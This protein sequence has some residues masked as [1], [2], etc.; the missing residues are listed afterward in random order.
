MPSRIATLVVALATFLPMGIALAE[1]AAN[2]DSLRLGARYL[3]WT[4]TGGGST[5]STLTIGGNA[6]V[7]PTNTPANTAAAPVPQNAVAPEVLLPQPGITLAELEATAEQ[8]NPTLTQAAAAV[9]AAH[10]QWLQSGLYPNPRVGYQASE[11]G[12]EGQAGQQGAMFGQEIVTAGKLQRA[13]DVDDQ[14]IQQAQWAWAAQRQRVQNDV[15]RAFYDV[16]VAQRSVELADQL[17]R[18]GQQGVNA[19]EALLK[20]KEVS[21]VDVLQARIE[22]DT[23]RIFADKAHNR[24][25]AAWR[26]LAAVVGVPNMQPGTLTGE[27]QDG[28]ALLTWDEALHSVLTDSPALAEA[29][30]GVARA[31]AAVGRECAGACRTST[32]RPACSTTTP[33]A[34]RLPKFRWECPCRP[35]IATR[36]TYARRRPN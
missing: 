25:L 35:S 24:H 10:G 18:I 7:A 34:T 19:A 30:A 9:Q 36:G 22:A 23:A 32:Y 13:R 28:L 15:R 11:I 8:N 3:R 4:P 33:P 31:V 14:A 17:V 5:T 27:L 12:D 6:P 1:E 26:N 29:R 21:R 16:L 20:A 2:L